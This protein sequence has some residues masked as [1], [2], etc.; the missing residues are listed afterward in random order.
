MGWLVEAG[1][2]SPRSSTQKAPRLRD[3]IVRG[4]EHLA[5]PKGDRKPTRSF[6]LLRSQKNSRICVFQPA[7]N[8]DTINISG[9][10]TILK[11]FNLMRQPYN[12]YEVSVIVFA[13]SCIGL[14]CCAIVLGIALFTSI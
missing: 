3:T 9:R 14:W 6:S 10:L 1:G 4:R 2:E 5:T 7:R 11:G 8:A 12:S 13:W